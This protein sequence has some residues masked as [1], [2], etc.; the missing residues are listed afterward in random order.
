MI[1]CDL[2][3]AYGSRNPIVHEFV[4]GVIHGWIPST[5]DMA[6]LRYSFQSVFPTSI[7]ATKIKRISLCQGLCTVDARLKVVPKR[8]TTTEFGCGVTSCLHLNQSC[9]HGYSCLV[10]DDL[11][12]G[13]LC[14][15]AGS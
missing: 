3:P 15:G 9:E 6:V 2:M 8:D 13:S 12:W 4:H 5:I 11:A 14:A 1:D 7:I 10:L